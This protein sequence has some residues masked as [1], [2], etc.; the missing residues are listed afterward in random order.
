MPVI[1]SSIYLTLKFFNNFSLHKKRKIHK[2]LLI[3]SLLI[4]VM[5]TAV[6]LQYLLGLNYTLYNGESAF[7]AVLYSLISS[8]AWCL[9]GYVFYENRDN[10]LC[11]KP[12][13]LISFLLLSV[14]L[15]LD[16]SSVV[17]YKS[18]IDRGGYADTKE[19]NHLLLSDSSIILLFLALSYTAKNLVLFC[20]CISI[21]ILYMLGGRSALFLFCTAFLMVELIRMGKSF[22]R[23]ARFFGLLILISF[24]ALFVFLENSEL[25]SDMLLGGGLSS[26][27]SFLLRLHQFQEGLKLLKEQVFIGNY[28]LVI[29]SFNSNGSY[30]HNILS[31]WQF[32]GFFA[33]SLLIYILQFQTRIIFKYRYQFKLNMDMFF[34]Y[35]FS[36]ALLSILLTKFIGFILLWFSLSYWAFRIPTLEIEA[37]KIH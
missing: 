13:M 28:G 10:H 24:I 32:Y 7:E 27:G 8:L 29:K 3:F 4:F 26:D 16:G 5:C 21:C 9:I 30:I 1:A 25:S 34:M 18:I 15:G 17:S 22:F 12:L 31:A 14:L 37:E 11:I 20:F 36:Y 6:F 35:I 19:L 33:F 2:S 23:T